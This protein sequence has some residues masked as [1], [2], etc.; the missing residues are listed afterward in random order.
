MAAI[1]YIALCFLFGGVICS[2][3]IP[4]K[5]G[6]FSKTFNGKETGLSEYFFRIPLW[7]ITGTMGLTW[8][9]YILACLFAEQ[10]NPLF[11][12]NSVGFVAVLTVSI[13]GLVMIVRRKKMSIK[14]EFLKFTQ[15]E[16]I[17][18]LLAVCLTGFLTY[19]SFHE[20]AGYLFTGNSV[21]GDF[22]PHL[23]MI[24]SFS[25]MNNFPTTY[26]VCAGSDVRYHFMFEFLVGNLEY[27]GLR[28]DIAFNLV[29]VLS[30]L[31]MFSLLYVLA[32]RIT[33]RKLVGGITVL[34]AAFRSSLSFFIYLSEF[35]GYKSMLTGLA[36]D[37]D[38]VGYTNHE[39]WG[40]WN[41]NVFI[42]QRHFAFAIG[43]LLIA[44]ILFMPV[45]YRS[46]YRMRGKWSLRNYF[47]LN[48]FTRD[49]FAATDIKT[50]VFAGLLLGGLAFFNGAV[51]IAALIVLFMM[52]VV[53]YK[54]LQYLLCAV[55][56]LML[57]FLQSGVF[58]DGSVVDP[59]FYF[60]FLADSPTVFSAGKYL[61]LLLGILPFVLIGAFIK[62][63][64]CKR[65]IMISFS[66]LIVFSFTVSLTPDIAVNHKYIMIAVIGL[67]IFAAQFLADML[68]DKRLIVRFT[69][70]VMGFVL[71]ATGLYDFAV[72][73][74]K[75][76]ED[77]AIITQID[78]PITE[79]I[80]KNCDSDD[81]FLT[82]NYFL[83]GSEGSYII[84]SGA[85]MYRA[86]Q[87]FGWSAGYDTSTRDEV[88][89]NIYNAQDAD[90]L[91][92]LVRAA[93]IDYIVVARANRES[94]DYVLNEQLIDSVYP[95]VFSV[96]DGIDMFKIYKT[97]DVL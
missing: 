3:L 97:A 24:R 64:A 81:V 93:D 29:S 47:K 57:S 78:N 30:I 71:T 28:L 85:S 95:A 20:R 39:E 19:I 76:T 66:A 38:F 84:L 13:F 94:A 82:S 11:L 42:N 9:V 27:M 55:I 21:F 92:Q 10:N 23:S 96:G 46:F 62:S 17:V 63:D 50:P 6:A 67:D 49:G 36:T 61:V 5:P 26:T 34:L 68:S 31:S 59:S 80:M 18:C 12:A 33:G 8:F 58:V 35:D 74:R 86:W 1:G 7:F 16:I 54:R 83:D 91:K 79:F 22:T 37:T 14:E 44:V 25:S 51:L 70:V 56:A 60:G 65:W 75:N 2:A 41:L 52:A 15:N 77:N 53:S 4:Y 48:L 88:A 87:Y 72:I 89:E 45:L 73:V 40:L 69:A 32:V 43:V 90:I